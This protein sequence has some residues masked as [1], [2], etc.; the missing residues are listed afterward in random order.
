MRGMTDTPSTPTPERRGQQTR[1][2]SDVT[3]E[4]LGK[5]AALAGARVDALQDVGN[6]IA[7]LTT[8]VA[9]LATSIE[10]MATKEEVEAASRA[11]DAKRR[12][13]TLALAAVGTVAALLLLLPSILVWVALGRL[14]EVADDNRANGRL[15]VECTTASP[16]EGEALDV[17]DRV[18]ECYE[19][20][21]SGQATAVATLT[22][23]TLDAAI[24]ARTEADPARLESC[25]L[26]RVKARSASTTTTRP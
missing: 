21:Q 20:S 11:Q 3:A 4:E 17:E 8:A 24:C 26:E 14:Q 23:S 22:F 5:L 1:R 16:K 10:S 18:H 9:N 12:R 2:A 6:D 15:L 7:A 13:Q 25:F 19:S